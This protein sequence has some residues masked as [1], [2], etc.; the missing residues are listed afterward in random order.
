MRLRG[1]F[2]LTVLVAVIASGLV[3]CGD[4]D[5]NTTAP[6]E[7]EGTADEGD[8]DRYCSL[9]EALDRAGARFFRKLEQEEGATQK[10]FEK[11]EAEFVKAHE[12]EIEELGEAA[13]SEIRTEV[14]TLLASLRARAGLGPDVNARETRAAERRV[15]RFEKSNC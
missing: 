12:D 1:V 9:V 2:Q 13:P 11:A 15:Q 7:Q 5:Q 6:P 8:T 4:E 14:E 10:D 3:A